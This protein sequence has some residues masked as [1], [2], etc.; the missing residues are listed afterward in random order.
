[1]LMMISGS[2]Q[3]WC[4]RCD[5]R[6]AGSVTIGGLPPSPLSL[7]HPLVCV[8]LCVRPCPAGG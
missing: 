3:V 7:Q 8:E 2:N 4:M 1:M 6:L 5:A